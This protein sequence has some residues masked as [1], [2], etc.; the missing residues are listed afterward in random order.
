M[1]QAQADPWSPRIDWSKMLDDIAYLLGDPAPENP[2][3]RVSVSQEKLAK[4]IGFPR[5]TVRYWMEGSEPRHG[6]GEVLIAHWCRLTGK[7]RTFVHVRH[8]AL[9][10]S[11]M[12][13]YTGGGERG[14]R[15]RADDGDAR[16]A[17]AW[18]TGLEFAR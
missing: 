2:L 12:A 5:G 11:K 14:S 8:Y 10:A 15:G 16:R 7:A 3:L 17:M 13:G 18:G 4:A 6:D 9:S 1:T